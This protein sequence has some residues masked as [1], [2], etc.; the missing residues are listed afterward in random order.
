MPGWGGSVPTITRGTWEPVF[1]DQPVQA[2]GALAASRSN[3]SVVWAGTAEAWTIRDADVMGDGVYRS[4]DVGTTWTHAGLRETGR[5]A[6][7]LVHPT[8]PDIVFACAL[9]RAT[10]PLDAHAGRRIV[11]RLDG[12]V[13]SASGLA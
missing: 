10:G 7:M 6:R 3:P 9:G 11:T 8:N 2:I 12:C 4:T 1:D 5:I 13:A